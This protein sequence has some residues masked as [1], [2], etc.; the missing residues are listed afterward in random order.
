MSKCICKVCVC[1]YI[2]C[3]VACVVYVLDTP[4]FV[5]IEWTIV[6]I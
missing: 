3:Y 2:E 1:M 5:V 4:Y 6:N